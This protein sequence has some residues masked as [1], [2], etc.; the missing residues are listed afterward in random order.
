MLCECVRSAT[1]A[2]ADV[3]SH[4]RELINHN[5]R[6]FLTAL[7][8]YEW[9]VHFWTS[10]RTKAMA[11]TMLWSGSGIYGDPRH[12]MRTLRFPL[13]EAFSQL[14]VSVTAVTDGSLG[15]ALSFL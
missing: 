9:N 10:A 13:A 5:C 12:A 11:A 3:F 7:P 6:F 2:Q 4:C 1:L 8:A 15:L 14:K